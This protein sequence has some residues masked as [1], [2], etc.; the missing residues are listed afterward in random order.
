MVRVPK[1]ALLLETS[2]EYGRGLLRG[3]VRYARLHG[4]WSVYMSP[5]HLEQVLPKAKSWGGDGIIARIQSPQMAKLIRATGLPVVA[6]S[7][8]EL[9][10]DRPPGDFCEIRTDSPGIAHMAAQHLMEQGLRHFAFC[11]FGACQWSCH[12]EQA[13]AQ[14]LAEAG[15]VCH[16]RHIQFANWLQRPDWIQTFEHERPIIE[17]WLESLPRPVGVMACNDACGRE[18]LQACATAGLHVPDDI[19]VVGVDNDELLCE[20]SEPPLS[21]VALNLDQAGYEAATLLDAMM[22]GRLRPRETV[23]VR[24]VT[25]VVRRSSEVI[26]QDD[27]LVVGAL[28]FIKDH[29]GQSI[30]VPDVMG[31]LPVSRRTMERR[32]AHAIKRS[33][34]S[35]ITRCH[36]DRAKRLLVDTDLPLHLVAASSGFPSIKTFNRTFRRVEGRT[37]TAFRCQEK[38]EHATPGRRRTLMRGRF[39]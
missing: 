4:P 14:R 19:A 25:V 9:T 15:F 29:T 6:S 3:V 20:L 2:T 7:L 26:A 37:A 24:P 30:G 18:V 23:L 31:E 16:K 33:I 1:V 8:R 5:G 27:P 12:R 36:L 17:R 28:R 10:W 11:G 21:S 22:S 32:F 13:F 34:L 39:G 38:A 35:E